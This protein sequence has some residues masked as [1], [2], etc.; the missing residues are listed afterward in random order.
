MCFKSNLICFLLAFVMLLASLTAEAKPLTWEQRQLEGLDYHFPS[1]MKDDLGALK[2]AMT[3]SILNYI[4]LC[5]QNLTKERV[6]LRSCRTAFGGCEERISHLVDYFI[7]SGQK[8]DLNPWLL[9]GMSYNES[10]FNPFAVGPTVASKGILQLNP[11]SKRGRKSKFIRN[12]RFREKCK[13][14]IGNCQEDIVDKAGDHIV[15]AIKK[16]DGSFAKGLSMYNTGRC[17]IRRRYIKNTAKAWRD[18]QYN[19]GMKKLSY[20]TTHKN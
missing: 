5:K 13:S 20:C 6:I 10:R 12:A 11:K 18:L 15:S 3:S 1:E 19:N 7:S 14:I 9:A 2:E 16:C 8:Y 4:M 17:E